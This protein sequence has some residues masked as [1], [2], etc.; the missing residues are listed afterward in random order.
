MT[1]P[2]TGIDVDLCTAAD[3][4][5]RSL[6]DYLLLVLSD[7][8]LPTGGFVASSGLESWLQHGYASTVADSAA[9]ATATPDPTA[10]SSAKAALNKDGPVN[11]F[12]SQS[13]DSYARLNAPLLRRAHA[14][15][16][17]V[18]SRRQTSLAAAG[19][20]ADGD[21]GAS[22]AALSSLLATDALCETMTLNH[23]ARRASVAQGVALLT[24]YERAFSPTPGSLEAS[25]DAAVVALVAQ[26]RLAIK[27]AREGANGHMSVAFGVLTAA[28]GISVDSA[29]HLFLFLHA[30]SLLSSAV[31]MNSIGPY[32]AHRVLVNDT[33]S[34]IASALARVA[35]EPAAG[36]VDAS[37]ARPGSE[38]EACQD[39]WESDPEWCDIWQSDARH[40]RH[41]VPATTWPLGEVVASRHDQ[42]FS[43]VFNS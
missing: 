3:D 1:M 36:T 7:S 24:L 31:R 32:L 34:M 23:V 4:V 28:I 38:E 17:E 33:R 2:G 27:L 22:E 37:T 42:L 16:A 25:R 41:G 39:W 18:R 40:T 13:L 12:I 21:N 30:R 6:E 8:N 26:Y 19:T 11:A 5:D 43:K 14:A 35:V 29:L 9:G 15:A 20:T 10:P